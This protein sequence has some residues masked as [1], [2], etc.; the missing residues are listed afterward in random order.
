MIL[1]EP[2]PTPTAPL[3]P[4]P[5]LLSLDVDPRDRLL[6]FDIA[7]DPVYVAME[8]QGFDDANHG[9]GLL[10]LLARHDG[11]VDVHRAP[12]LR[13]DRG[14]LEIGRGVGVWTETIIDP[15]VL[16]VGPTGVR[17]EIGLT[18][19][20]G[21]RVEVSLDDRD[22][23]LRPQGSLLAPVGSGIERPGRL[24]LVLLHGFDLARTSGARPRLS[25]GGEERTLRPFPGPAWLHHRRFIRSSSEP[26]IVSFAP[27]FEGP[28]DEGSLGP[29]GRLDAGSGRCTASVR[30][31]PPLPA[32]RALEDRARGNGTWQI[33]V[34]DEPALTGG[35]WTV[36]RHDGEVCLSFSVTRRWRP[37]HLQPAMRVV[38]LLAPV[39]RSWPTTY[40][41]DATVDVSVAPAIARTGWSRITGPDRADA[42]GTSRARRRLVMTGV[43][44][45]I[46]VLLAIAAGRSARR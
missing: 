1:S 43:G 4:L 33:D 21:R 10:V 40:R 8:I 39:F 13:V 25:I 41:W 22:G 32:L 46:G 3:A 6:L 35:E 23:R 29:V 34:A 45:I 27:G 2:S 36:E 38:T 9:R 11:T 7:D 37:V 15:A 16:E 5:P 24:L 26:I 31:I 19:I 17:V 12:G 30:F 14:I 42:Y 18:D 44:A 20:D 28:V